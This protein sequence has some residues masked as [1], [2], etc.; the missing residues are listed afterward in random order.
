VCKK[1][2]KNSQRLWGKWE[3]SGPLREDFFWLTL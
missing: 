2:I 3:M 1:L